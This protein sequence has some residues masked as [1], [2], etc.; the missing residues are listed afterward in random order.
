MVNWAD[1]QHLAL[2][3]QAL[4]RMDLVL[5][6]AFTWEY[7]QTLWF[8]WS[9]L[10]RKVSFKW[11]YIPYF[12]GR[13]ITLVLLAT[14]VS[15]D[16]NTHPLN[17]AAAYRFVNF[18]G[19]VGAS[20]ATLNLLIRT[21]VLW[22]HNK[23]VRGVLYVALLGHWTLV[24]MTLVHQRAV[25]NPMALSCTAIFA[26]RTQLLAQFLYT[27]IFDLVILILTLVALTR[28]RSPSKLW[29]KLYT[30]GIGYFF[31]ASCASVA[32]AVLIIMALS[33][34]MDIIA[35]GPALTISVIASSRAVLSLLDQA[36]P[37]STV[38]VFSYNPA[39]SFC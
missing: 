20:C 6:G 28:D 17:C 16:T 13:Y 19:A 22:R 30:Q 26:D 18:A 23:W 29:L 15:L 39:R 35:I 37:E 24:F 2:Q 27:F 5:L 10:A 32:P 3:A 34:L 8:E 1:P 7:L 4:G 33:P 38:Y 25:W 9:L 36:V 31:V 11:A 21:L 14:T 12:I